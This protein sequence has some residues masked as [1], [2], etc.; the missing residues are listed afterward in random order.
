MANRI[1]TAQDAI[2]FHCAREGIDLMIDTANWGPNGIL[3][4]KD[5]PLVSTLATGARI[6]IDCGGSVW[7]ILFFKVRYTNTYGGQ[8][9]WTN[10]DANNPRMITNVNGQLKINWQNGTDYRFEVDDVEYLRF[11]GKYEE[12]VSGDPNYPGHNNGYGFLHGTYGI[13]IDD[14]W[15]TDGYRSILAD[16][17]TSHLEIDH[18]ETGNGGFSN[19][20]NNNKS[21]STPPFPYTDPVYMNVHDMLSINHAGETYYI[22]STSQQPQARYVLTFRNNICLWGGSEILQTNNLLD[23]SVIENNVLAMGGLRWKIPFQADQAGNSQQ[24]YRTGGIIYRNNIIIG[25]EQNIFLGKNEWYDIV[26]DTSDGI[27]VVDIYNNLFLM[28][29]RYGM[30]VTSN[31]ASNP[32][33]RTDVNF[34][35]NFVGKFTNLEG[36][37]YLDRGDEDFFAR[38]NNSTVQ[39]YFTDNKRDTS[40]NSFL[41][42]RGANKTEEGTTIQ[43][44]D[45]PQFKNNGYADD[46]D[47][48]QVEIWG[49]LVAWNRYSDRNEFDQFYNKGSFRYNPSKYTGTLDFSSQIVITLIE[50]D[51][52]PIRCTGVGTGQVGIPDYTDYKDGDTLAK[53]QFRIAK[54]GSEDVD[55]A[56]CEMT[57]WNNSTKEATFAIASESYG[58]LTGSNDWLIGQA[59]SFITYYQGQTLK[60]ES[61]Q[62]ESLNANAQQSWNIDPA[63]DVSGQAINGSGYK[64]GTHFQKKYWDDGGEWS[65]YPPMGWDLVVGSTYDLLNMG[66]QST[67]ELPSN[68]GIK[69][70][71]NL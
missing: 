12:G 43:T 70:L 46:F 21:A 6:I 17:N 32:A 57:A 4:D 47:F 28:P 19:S 9:L 39:Y 36:Q 29:K 61:M 53:R 62:Y 60:H 37:L 54:R 33:K 51:F 42:S 49:Q 38:V 67:N 2:D 68:L 56:I 22:A 65:D 7:T 58:T 26:D 11:T 48:G 5:I 44:I 24:R 15:N 23:G 55:F 45:D 16:Y 40:Y 10:N 59:Q 35:E 66:I 3:I 64:V 1:A 30:H 31:F 34:Y 14:L 69:T 8:L 27:A 25:G 71:L 20:L 63:A 52:E 41:E 13:R 50:C 18:I